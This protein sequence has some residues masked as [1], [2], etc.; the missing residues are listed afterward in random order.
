MRRLRMRACGFALLLCA[1]PLVSCSEKA[2]L[3][4]FEPQYVGSYRLIRR[5]TGLGPLPFAA[6]VHLAAD[7]R[8]TMTSVPAAWLGYESDAESIQTCSGTWR[9]G[10][11]G[12]GSLT[13]EF[14]ITAIDGKNATHAALARAEKNGFRFGPQGNTLFARHPER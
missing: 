14:S 3:S 12:D 6:E 9:A 4:S 10:D 11:D 2:D 13:L 1:V 7:K 5:S 8:F